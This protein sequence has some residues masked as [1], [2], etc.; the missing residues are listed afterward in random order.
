MDPPGQVHVGVPVS[1]P[2][3]ARSRHFEVRWLERLLKTLGALSRVLETDAF[4]PD[5]HDLT[6]CDGERRRSRNP[7]VPPTSAHP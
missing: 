2:F 3:P 6:S 7:R 5:L 4:I 1:L